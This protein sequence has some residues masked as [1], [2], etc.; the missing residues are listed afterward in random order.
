MGRE[1]L[2]SHTP[3]ISALLYLPFLEVKLSAAISHALFWKSFI[4]LLNKAPFVTDL[5]TSPKFFN[6][7]LLL[8]NEWIRVQN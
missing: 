4:T 6:R 5:L 2:V 3:D 8:K 7:D 1:S